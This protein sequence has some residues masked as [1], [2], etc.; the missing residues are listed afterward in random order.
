MLGNNN[1]PRVLVL[2]DSERIGGPGKGLLQLISSARRHDGFTICSFR[3]PNEEP[4]EFSEAVGA[5]GVESRTIYQRFALDPLMIRQAL[6]IAHDGHF[7]VV[8]SHGYKTHLLAAIVSRVMN[9]PWLAVSHGWT[10]EN[11]KVRLYHWLDKVLLR[12]PDTVVAVSPTLQGTIE[13]LRPDARTVTIL[14]AVDPQRMSDGKVDDAEIRARIRDELGVGS[15]D[16]LLGVIGRLS[17]EKGQDLILRALA[18]LEGNSGRPRVVFLGEG[19]EGERLKSLARVLNVT[20]QVIFAGYRPAIHEYLRAMDLVVLPSR[21]EGLPNVVLE[22]QASGKPVVAYRVGGVAETIDHGETGWLVTPE[23][24]EALSRAIRHVMR[25]PEEA[26]RV[27]KD[28]ARR[29]FPRF[30]VETRCRAFAYEYQRLCGETV[31]EESGV[32]LRR[33]RATS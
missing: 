15:S 8:Q 29:L 33:L 31:L 18:R 3:H 16:F 9:V 32:P 14:N 25:S 24:T 7:Q 22:A 26:E 17:P 13:R 4:S 2:F 27:G 10:N 30:S 19:P 11:T 20:D 12:L 23:D 1:P 21:S 28:A 6:K 5:L